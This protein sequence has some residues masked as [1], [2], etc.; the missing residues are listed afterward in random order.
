LHVEKE[1]V[2]LR[3][4]VDERLETLSK[5]IGALNTRFW[6]MAIIVATLVVG[7]NKAVQVLDVKTIIGL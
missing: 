7:V 6:K 2:D 3:T 5:S 1:V 4:D